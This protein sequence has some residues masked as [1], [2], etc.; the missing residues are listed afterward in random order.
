MNQQ[1]QTPL[2]IVK[3]F[4]FGTLALAVL[5]SS[6]TTGWCKKPRSGTTSVDYNGKPVGAR[7]VGLGE[8]ASVLSGM[9]EAPAWNPAGLLDIPEPMFSTDYD[10][11]RQSRI[12]EDVLVSQS[13]L[14]GRKLTYVGFAGPGG[15]FFYRPLASFT[16]RTVTNAADPLNNFTEKALKINQY[17]F[18]AS[19][20]GDKGFRHGLTLSYLNARRGLAEAVSGQPPVLELADGNGFAI[21]LGFQVKKEYFTFGTTLFNTP[22]IIYWNKYKA[23]QLPVLLR[24][25]MAFYPASFFSFVAE[26]EKRFYRGGL[27]KPDYTHLGMEITPI[28]WIQLRGGTFSEDLNDPELTNYTA[29][30]SVAS[31]KKHQID[32]ALKTYRFQKE[33]VY[34]YFISLILPLPAS[35]QDKKYSELRNSAPFSKTSHHRDSS[36][37]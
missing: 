33:R 11:A 13:P 37:N 14:R 9:P 12:K 4:L 3:S 30:F 36:F 6:T 16:E 32:F 1:K 19:V 20:D 17:G 7:F 24:S 23:D 22:G 18:S 8:I 31:A 10:V 25:G 5:L 34:N 27:P 28:R 29:G 35:M 21:D 15:A 26:Y 2:L